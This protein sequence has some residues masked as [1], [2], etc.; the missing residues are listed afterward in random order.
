[1][2]EPERPTCAA[3]DCPAEPAVPYDRCL[4]HVSAEELAEVVADYWPGG[5]L[6]ARG[7]TLDTDRLDRIL[8]GF[9]EDRGQP[10]LVRNAH[11]EGARFLGDA[12][13]RGVRFAGDARFGGAAFSGDGSFEDCVFEGVAAFEEA[14][15]SGRGDFTGASFGEA[16]FD[17]AR[18]TADALFR[19]ARF[20]GGGGFARIVVGGDA[21]FGGAR[22][23]EDAWFPGARF[24]RMAALGEAVFGAGAVFV[25]VRFGGEVDIGG[26][27]FGA[28]AAFSFARFERAVRLGPAVVDG[29]LAL[30]GAAFDGSVQIEAVA[31]AVTAFQASFGGG[32]GLRLRYARVVLDGITS[33]GPVTVAAATEPFALDTGTTVDESTVPAGNPAPALMSLRGVDAARL[34][35]VNLDLSHCRFTDAYNL[36]EV[37]LEGRCRFAGTPTW[38]RA[39]SGPLWWRYARRQTIVE[40]HTWREGHRFPTRHSDGERPLEPER[41]ATIYRQLRKALEDAK[42]EPGAADFYYGEMEMRRHAP[43][44]QAGERRILALYWALSGYGLRASR[45]IAALLLLLLLTTTGFATVGF[46]ASQ[47]TEY[48]PIAGQAGAYAQTVT[49]GPKPGWAAALDHSLDS[50]TSLLRTPEAPPLTQPGK[51]L[52]ITLRLLGPLLLGLAVLAV[53]NRVKR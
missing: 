15:F 39:R 26:A 27:R 4:G 22:F 40:E 37:Q 28:D 35:L 2:T 45:A 3:G 52:E 5:D 21:D 42:N 51:V 50:A 10:A 25:G 41:L 38:V 14:L 7:V 16:S 30:D 29:K 18:F 1:M 44:T 48:H 34:V 8:A 24:D 9:R 31:A 20:A 36:D 49:A 53:R 19:G 43:T 23:D 46:A 12:S 47:R 32:A 13:F 6:D 33:G 17:D 11:F